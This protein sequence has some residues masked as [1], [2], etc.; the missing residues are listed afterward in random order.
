LPYLIG[1]ENVR[2]IAVATLTVTT[3]GQVTFRKEV[4]RHLGVEPGD[5]ISLDFLPDGRVVLE[6]APHSGTLHDFVGMLAGRTS[7]VAT[8][9][10][11]D[12]AAAR[13]WAGEK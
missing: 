4:L 9:E 13:G 11:I 10:E 7:K 8:L 2:I 3:R 5:K 1:F 12:E 6:A